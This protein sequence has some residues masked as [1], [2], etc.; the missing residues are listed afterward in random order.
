MVGPVCVA[1]ARTPQGRRKG[2]HRQQKEDAGHLQPQDAAY[3]AK[4]AQKTANPLRY[5]SPGP[6]RG[7]PCS[8]RRCSSGIS[9]AVS[10]G[11]GGLRNC[12]WRC[13]L[14]SGRQ[15]LA[16]NASGHAQTDAQGAANGLRSHPVYDGSSDSHR[17]AFP[18]LA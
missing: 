7:P 8:L 17:A 14:R 16:G 3:A 10:G 5:S 18:T 1:Q 11:R 9:R 15:A 12:L 6:R 13:G 4:R 2:Q